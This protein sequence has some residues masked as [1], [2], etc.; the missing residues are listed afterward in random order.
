M[1]KNQHL[2]MLLSPP[3]DLAQ[4]LSSALETINKQLSLKIVFLASVPPPTSTLSEEEKS[5]QLGLLDRIWVINNLLKELEFSSEQPFPFQYVS[6]GYNLRKLDEKIASLKSYINKHCESSG[7]STPMTTQ[8]NLPG[9][10]SEFLTLQLESVVL[11]DQELTAKWSQKDHTRNIKIVRL[12][13]ARLIELQKEFLIKMAALFDRFVEVEGSE[14]RVVLYITSPYVDDDTIQETL[15]IEEFFSYIKTNASTVIRGLF[16]EHMESRFSEFIHGLTQICLKM[17]QFKVNLNEE[18]SS[19]GLSIDSQSPD[20]LREGYITSF[21][22]VVYFLLKTPPFLRQKLV[23]AFPKDK[24]SGFT[25]FHLL[26]LAH[27]YTQY[28][29][30]TQ[31]IDVE[32]IK[33]DIVLLV[34]LVYLLV[35][36]R[37]FHRKDFAFLNINIG[38]LG[39]NSSDEQFEGYLQEMDVSDSP[40]SEEDVSIW[41]KNNGPLVNFCLEKRLNRVI[42]EIKQYLVQ[43]DPFDAIFDDLIERKEVDFTKIGPESLEKEEL[44]PEQTEPAPKVTGKKRH[45]HSPSLSFSGQ[46]NIMAPISESA[47]IDSVMNE[48]KPALEIGVPKAKSNNRRSN[49]FA[50]GGQTASNLGQLNEITESTEPE[51]RDKSFNQSALDSL[52]GNKP[53]IVTSQYEK[54]E[55]EEHIMSPM[56]PVTPLSPFDYSNLKRF[57][58]ADK[59]PDDDRRRL[60]KRFS[61]LQ[62]NDDASVSSASETE[63]APLGRRASKRISKRLSKRF[64]SMPSSKSMTFDEEEGEDGWGLDLDLDDEDEPDPDKTVQTV[65]QSSKDGE[66]KAVRNLKSFNS[67]EEELDD[68]GWGDD[69]LDLDLPVSPDP[70]NEDKEIEFTEEVFKSTKIPDSVGKIIMSFV[71]E[72]LRYEQAELLNEKTEITQRVTQLMKIYYLIGGHLKYE[73]KFLFYNDMYFLNIE[74]KKRLV[75]LGVLE[76]PYFGGRE[77]VDQKIAFKGPLLFDEKIED[78][79]T[80]IINLEKISFLKIY[81]K[82]Q[83]FTNLAGAAA[84]GTQ[85]ILTQL[86]FKFKEIFFSGG[87]QQLLINL[88]HIIVINFLNEFYQLI[89]ND[90]LQLSF[91]LEVDSEELCKIVSQMLYFVKFFER[92]DPVDIETLVKVNEKDLLKETNQIVIFFKR[93]ISNYTKLANFKIIISSHLASIMENFYNG[94]FYN[95]ET[96]ELIH[97]I[98]ALFVESDLRRNAVKEIEEIRNIDV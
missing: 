84:S 31:N 10:F 96:E 78:Y 7:A 43:F 59:R 50:L 77:G 32:Q 38:Q 65:T 83:N 49:I 92:G 37:L 26:S 55:S 21:L 27:K 75:E 63:G 81:R 98:K 2:S 13:E 11:T 28:A 45:G 17:S 29:T 34:R 62:P 76:N 79:L 3:A 12:F 64:S 30:N 94:E 70:V 36:L 74:L 35:N 87:F 18:G 19:L 73:S 42:N 71:E 89:I 54:D 16:R 80:N 68:W 53:S 48:E 58:S 91:I 72:L 82:F 67:I 15:S 5:V 22:K 39:V 61:A 57:S 44:E 8:L 95:V 4:A 23:S 1:P 86:E 66:K 14:V 88:Q 51:N 85:M 40:L 6:I 60:S 52:V 9:S 93:N 20:S 69:E 24:L 56:L 25:G 41:N 90:I 97:L 33:K 46:T 47:S